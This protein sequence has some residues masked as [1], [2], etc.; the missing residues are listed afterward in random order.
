MS[1]ETTATWQKVAVIIA[2]LTVALP[3]VSRF[4]WRVV[5]PP[6]YLLYE[7]T[8]TTRGEGIQSA[9]IV[10]TNAGLDVQRDVA[11]YL[12]LDSAN[13]SVTRVEVSSPRRSG[14]RSLFNADP[15]VPLSTFAHDAGFK[16]PLGNIGPEEEVRV[17]LILVANDEDRFTPTLSL[18]DARVE[19]ASMSAIEADGHRRPQFGDDAHSVYVQLAPYVLAMLLAVIGLMIF[20]SIIFDV[21]FDT[22][23]QKMTRLWRQ[24]DQLQEQI[25]KERRYQ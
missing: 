12:S 23:Q 1:S 14:L 6:D 24:M 9:S 13:A 10:V 8:H 21:F 2:V 15:K 25:D 17:T 7:T 4:L 22:P 5:F 3:T 11:L 18:S 16:V 20:L 19:S